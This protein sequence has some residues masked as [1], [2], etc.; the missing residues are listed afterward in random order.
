MNK[1]SIRDI[2]NLTGVKAHTIRIWEQRYGILQPKRTPTNIRYYDADDLKLALRITLLNDYGYKIS[3]IHQMKADEMSN[4]I[5]QINDKGFRLQLL[6]NE[7]IELTLSL[8]TD[9]F[10]QVLDKYIESAGIEE[11]VETLIF[12]YLEKL[13]FMWLA[14]RL[15]PAQEHLVSN[16][17]Y[18]KIALAIDKLPYTTDVNAPVYMLFLPEGEVHELGLLYVYYMVRKAK[19][20]PIYLGPNTPLK[21][22]QMVYDVRKPAYVYVHLTSVAGDFET[23][24][25]LAKISEMF[26]ESTVYVSGR[27]L[28]HSTVS[29]YPNIKYLHSLKDVK[30][31][32]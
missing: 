30:A 31:T 32:I 14:E 22:A 27:M 19:K 9:S 25:Y 11:A 28:T 5:G 24:K 21:D 10:E 4:I 29:E 6:V 7:L 16:I 15:F 2:E 17:V 20:R 23:N 26:T 8:D 1:F 12:G 3:R 18:R 13:G